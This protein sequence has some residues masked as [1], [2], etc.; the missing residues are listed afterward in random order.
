MQKKNLFKIQGIIMVK[1]LSTL[2]IEENYFNIIKSIYENPTA[3]LIAN[4][5]RMKIL[6]MYI[7]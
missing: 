2:G 7:I 6:Q 5:E 1:R 4:G 3:N